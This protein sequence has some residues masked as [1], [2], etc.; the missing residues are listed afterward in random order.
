MA[1]N[2]KDFFDPS[3]ATFTYLLWDENSLAAAII[4]S[5]LNYDQCSAS[6]NSKSADELIVFIKKNNL[7]LEWILETHIHA[8]HLTAARYLQEKLGG[9]IGIG[10]GIRAVLQYWIPIFNSAC[11]IPQDGSQFDQI[12]EDNEII[13]LGLSEIKV[14]HSPGHTPACVSYLIADAIFVGDVI[15]MPDIGTARAD[16]PGGSADR[17]Y[18]SLQRILSLPETTRIFTAHDYPPSGRTASGMSNVAEQKQHNILA[19]ISKAEF[20]TARNKRDEG[21]PIPKLLLPALQF[22]LRAGSF[23][24]AEVNGLQYIKIPVNKF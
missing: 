15:L 3:T 11:D 8:D 20:I 14:L 4:D 21:K 22:N 19:K 1:I 10:S 13:K 24:K 12:F 5:V 16:F 6:T 23:G 17:L 7:K 2:S 9:K 18:D